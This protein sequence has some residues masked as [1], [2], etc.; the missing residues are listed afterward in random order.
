MSDVKFDVV[1]WGATGFTGRW[2]AKHLYEHYP[3]NK[4]SWAIAGRNPDKMDEVREFI[5]DHDNRVKGILADSADEASLLDMVSNT[6]VI[7]STVGPYAYYGSMLVKACAQTGTH[8][9]DLTGEVP[10]MREMIDAHSDAAKSSGARIVHTCGFDSIPSDIGT[11]HAQQ[12]AQ[13]QYGE[14][15]KSV[16]YSLIKVRGGISGGTVHSLLNLM[17]QARTDKNI[18][19]LLANPYA[20]NPDPSDKGFDKLDQSTAKYSEQLGMWTAPFVMAGVNTRVV[21]R[22]NALLDYVWGKD[23]SYSEC[24]ATRNGVLGFAVA[25]SIAAGFAAFG[26]VALTGP[27]RKLLAMLLPSQGRGPKVDP[28]DPGLY[29]I[30]FHGETSSGEEIHTRLEGDGDP[31]Y[32]ST[33]KML[34][35][36]A[37][38]LA[39]DG[40]QITV[41]GGFW[42]PASA[43]GV[44]LLKRL[45]ALGGLSFSQ[46]PS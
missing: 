39:L 24:V 1:V 29:V 45:Q 12:M 6:R 14:P 33:S 8:Y 10:W 3:Q 18:R 43:M 20:L 19:R 27:G 42:T 30:D 2:V 34:A 11:F 37:V 36:S 17:K 16:R 46:R 5:G 23:F 15:L 40:D 25:S 41:G 31:G 4:L 26:A 21:R 22:T 38:C 7:I 35:E 44:P 32:G 9:V 13:K 28:N